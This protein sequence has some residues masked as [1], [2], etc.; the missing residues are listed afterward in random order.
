MQGGGTVVV[1][2]S[3]VF[4]VVVGERSPTA[5]ECDRDVRRA[6]EVSAVETVD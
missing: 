3:D 6:L 4:A 2:R 1:V 5:G